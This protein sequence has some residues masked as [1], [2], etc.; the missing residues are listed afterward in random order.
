M[1]PQARDEL[2]VHLL[3][4][5]APGFEALLAE[6]PCGSRPPMLKC[7]L[8]TRNG[9]HRWMGVNSYGYTDTRKSDFSGAVALVLACEGKPVAAGLDILLRATVKDK[10]P[11]TYGNPLGWAQDALRRWE[12][13]GEKPVGTLVYLDVNYTEIPNTLESQ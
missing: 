8:G 10:L 2:T 9:E 5:P 13:W 11:T 1:T 12:A 3:L 6:G 4:I 7:M